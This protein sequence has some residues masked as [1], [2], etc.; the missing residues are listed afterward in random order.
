VLGMKERIKSLGGV[1]H[2]RSEP[3]KGTRIS[4]SVPIG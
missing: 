2:I 1:F 3:E 4:V